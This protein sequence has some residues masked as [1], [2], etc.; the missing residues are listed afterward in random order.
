MIKP[1][2]PVRAVVMLQPHRMFQ[3]P[4]M[5]K[6]RPM[7]LH[8]PATLVAQHAIVVTITMIIMVLTI[9]VGIKPRDKC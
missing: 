5:L 2:A 6:K 1:R 3:R 8:T 4:L 7:C 9:P